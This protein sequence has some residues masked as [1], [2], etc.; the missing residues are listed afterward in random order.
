M[1]LEVPLCANRMPTDSATR[2]RMSLRGERGLD[3][4]AP[5]ACTEPGPPAFRPPKGISRD[6]PSS[7]RP[8]PHLPHSAPIPPVLLGVGALPGDHPVW[9]CLSPAGLAHPGGPD[10]LGLPGHRLR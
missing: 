2:P 6:S 9:G 8:P 5:F 1:F 7:P 10:A 3:G 4:G